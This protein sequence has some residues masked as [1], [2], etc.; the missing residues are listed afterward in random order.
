MLKFFC[1]GHPW[2]STLSLLSLMRLMNILPIILPYNCTIKYCAYVAY[3][4]YLLKQ[5]FLVL[6]L[7]CIA[8]LDGIPL[9]TSVCKCEN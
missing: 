2:L 5:I 6:I 3:S 4:S 9:G 1:K 7:L 8:L